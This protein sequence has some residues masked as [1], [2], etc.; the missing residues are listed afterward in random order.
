M[1]SPALTI[2]GSRTD[3]EGGL[4]TVSGYVSEPT[5]VE[6]SGDWACTVSCPGL[7]P[8]EIMPDYSSAQ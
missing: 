8:D 7:F 3:E 2:S 4:S 5:P 1:N 6:Q